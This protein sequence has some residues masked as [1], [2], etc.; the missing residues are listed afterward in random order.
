MIYHDSSLWDYYY[1]KICS[2]HVVKYVDIKKYKNHHHIII[3][4]TKLTTNHINLWNMCTIHIN[5]YK[6]QQHPRL[7]VED[8]QEDIRKKINMED[9]KVSVIIITVTLMERSL[10]L[11]QFL[12]NLLLFVAVI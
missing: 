8:Y 11:D 4:Q 3:M 12:L 6:H 9:L 10:L 1:M 2:K 7:D 5:V